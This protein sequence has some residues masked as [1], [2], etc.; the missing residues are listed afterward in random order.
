[1]PRPGDNLPG[2]RATQLAFAAHIRH[3]QQNPAPA[4]IEARRMRIYT[5]LFYNNVESF[6]AGAFPVAKQ[7]LGEQARWHPLVRRFLHRH[8]SQSPYFL[9]ISQ[10]FLAF[11][12]AADEGDLP[13]FLLELCHYEWVELA[14]SVADEDL[15]QV[16]ADRNGDLA[17]GVPLVSPLIWKLGYQYPVHR[18]GVANQPTR[19]P[20]QPTQLIVYRCRDDRVRFM[21]VSGLTLPLLDAL[22][23]ERTGEQ[24]LRCL[25]A[26]TP[27]LEPES[28]YEMGLATL[29]RLR[30]AEIV[31][32]TRRPDV[33]TE[34]G[35]SP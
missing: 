25:I 9:E 21:E 30:K 2:Y 22:D 1:M 26:E 4:G 3:P 6:L 11:L 15:D 17:V 18:I 5:D 16:A 23:G 7:I 35:E 12:A 24:A 32:G 13:P 34:Q 19:P 29:E 31:L 28:A 8:G 14:L 27:G 33:P 10:E 20:A